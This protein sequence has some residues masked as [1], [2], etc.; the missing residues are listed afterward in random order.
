M[1]KPGAK[2]ISNLNKNL[3]IIEGFEAV[4]RLDYFEKQENEDDRQNQ[5][6]TAASVI[7]QTRSHSIAAET[8]HQD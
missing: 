3:A 7:A 6:Q 4:I 1:M 2:E 8:K 5:T